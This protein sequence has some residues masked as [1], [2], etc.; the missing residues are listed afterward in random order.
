MFHSCSIPFLEGVVA[1]QLQRLLEET[2]YLDP[3]QLGFRPGFG[4]ET[5]LVALYDD[6]CR[7]KDR[8][9]VTLLILLDLSAAFNTIDHSI[10]LE[11]LAE[12]GVGGTA[13]QRFRSY[14]AGQIQKVVLGE[15]CSAPW[16]LHYGVLQGS[17]LSPMLFNIYM[18]PLGA[19]IWSFGVHCHQYAD[20]TQ[21]YFSFSSSSGE[22]VDVLN[23]CLAATMDWMRANKLKLNPDKTEMLLV[24]GSSDQIAGVQP[25]L[26]GEP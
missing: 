17:V 14:L 8:G 18:K 12:F 22:A 7:A 25:V 15:H 6:L 21:L 5:A 19:V 3:F 11:Q 23:P 24:A 4:T 9:S 10:L 2:D 1:D 13:L 26:D 20:D 16:V